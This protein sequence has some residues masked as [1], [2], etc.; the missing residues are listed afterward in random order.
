MGSTSSAQLLLSSLGEF[1][2]FTAGLHHEALLELDNSLLEKISQTPPSYDERGNAAVYYSVVN[3]LLLVLNQRHGHEMIF[4]AWAKVCSIRTQRPIN[5]YSFVRSEL[6]PFITESP[7]WSSSPIP[8]RAQ[9]TILI[10]RWLE[11][12]QLPNCILEEHTVASLLDNR[13]RSEILSDIIRMYEFHR[14]DFSDSGSL[15]ARL[16]ESG[17]F[18]ESSNQGRPVYTDIYKYLGLYS[19]TWPL[20]IRIS[21]L[22]LGTWMRAQTTLPYIGYRRRRGLLAIVYWLVIILLPVFF[23]LWLHSI[24]AVK[25]ARLLSLK[26]VSSFYMNSVPLP[27]SNQCAGTDRIDV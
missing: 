6:I 1:V 12:S 14:E 24:F 25:R 8:F 26:S 2:Q 19:R 22:W 9:L 18:K 13:I 3:Y 23:Y 5:D 21:F 20:A 27:T 15:V 10:A 7:D 4:Q 11:E 17:H 16:R